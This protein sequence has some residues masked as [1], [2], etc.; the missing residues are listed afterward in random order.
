MTTSAGR[1]DGW[2]LSP[3]PPEC[4]AALRLAVG[5]YALANVFIST[6]EFARLSNRPAR[7]F[8]PVGLAGLLDGPVSPVVLWA[9]FV[10]SAVSGVAFVAGA[11]FRLSGPIFA[12]ASLAWA[13]YHAS[14]GQMLHFEHLVLLHLLLLGFSPA[15]DGS[16]LDARRS[17][18]AGEGSLRMA[19]PSTGH[20]H[21]RHLRAG[22]CGQAA[23]R[24]VDVGRGH[25]TRQP[26]RWPP[27][28]IS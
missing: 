8:E 28:R 26:H 5:G 22:R 15:A 2:L 18:A 3:A 11:A 7:Q 23:G 25:H 1:L 21:R 20:H 10:V 4:L 16:S 27:A 14:W 6:G 9:L 19:R 24:R 12:L 13:T 17:R